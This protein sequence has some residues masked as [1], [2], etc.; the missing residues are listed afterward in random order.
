MVFY[1]KSYPNVPL[2]ELIIFGF[3]NAIIIFISIFIHELAHLLVAQRYELVITEIELSF[4]GGSFDMED[5][6]KKPNDLLKVYVAGP[7]SNLLIGV[8]LF[9]VLR[10]PQINFTNF[11]YMSLSLSGFA[12]IILAVFNFIPTFPLDGGRIL[13]A[14][15]LSDS[16]DLYQTMKVV[17]IVGTIFSFG[18]IL[19]GFYLIIISKFSDAFWLILIGIFLYLSAWYSYRYE[20]S[21]YMQGLE[22]K[23]KKVEKTTV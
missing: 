9:L 12:N 23:F 10:I 4:I 17:F 20:I 3:V 1:T 18:F 8:I 2:I 13:K 15:I 16:D 21:K 7:L 22:E 6:H 14:S 5:K 19:Y 11:I